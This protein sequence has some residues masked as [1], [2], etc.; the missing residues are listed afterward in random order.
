MAKKK[1]FAITCN[2]METSEGTV[3]VPSSFIDGSAVM[4]F[5]SSDYDNVLSKLEGTDFVPVKTL[6]GKAITVLGFFEYRNSSFGPYKEVTL[7]FPVLPDNTTAPWSAGFDFFRN[8]ENRK[9]G[10]HIIDLPITLE[11]PHAA[12]REIWGFPKFKADIEYKY[13]KSKFEANVCIHE[14][15][16][17]IL[18][19][20]SPFCKGMPSPFSDCIFYSYLNDTILKSIVSMNSR[21]R[22]TSGSGTELS[23]GSADHRMI[24][25]LRDLGLDGA[26]PMFVQATNTLQ[27]KLH[28]CIKIKECKTPSLPYCKI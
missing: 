3:Q 12:G 4:A 26:K 14:T 28:E 9:I 25:N 21:G 1:F 24:K 22:I 7:S 8:I 20:K 6:K 15:S 10:F 18:T 11:L 2:T 23:I 16:D 19:F 13:P 27:Y 5:F 17:I